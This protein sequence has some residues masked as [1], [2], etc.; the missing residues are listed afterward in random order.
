[1]MLTSKKYK[2]HAKIKIR[3]RD[4]SYKTGQKMAKAI[5]SAVKPELVSNTDN[6]KINIVSSGSYIYMQIS[7]YNFISIRAMFNSFILYVYA[8]HG[9][10]NN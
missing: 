3:V 7:A 5:V 8:A 10:L 6:Q 2:I 9:S 1:M 4:H